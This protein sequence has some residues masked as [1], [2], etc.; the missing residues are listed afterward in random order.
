VVKLELAEVD[1]F[2]GRPGYE[3]PPPVLA[4]GADS[5]W[6]VE[7]VLD[8]KMRYRSLWYFVRFKG[9]DNSHDQWVKHSDVFAPDAIAE[10]YRK[11]P[12]KPRAIAA[13]TF[14]ALPFQDPATS[15][16]HIRAM[17]R[18]AAFQGGGDV[19]GTPVSNPRSSDRSSDPTPGSSDPTPGQT[20]AI[21]RRSPRRAKPHLDGSPHSAWHSA[22][23][24]ARDHCRSLRHQQTMRN[25]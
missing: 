16:A 11:Y 10:F 4:D 20:S 22:C 2:G 19:R 3:E 12:G 23:D 18:G 15:S 7:E 24:R 8:A 25:P 5:E 9:Y 14:D 1:P 13:A 17:R 6:E 21:L